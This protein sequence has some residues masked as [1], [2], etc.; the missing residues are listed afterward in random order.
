VSAALLA[1]VL[2]GQDR[3]QAW[4]TGTA[5]SEPLTAQTLAAKS[6]W[7][8]L[9]DPLKGDAVLS[10]GR[11]TA[12]VRRQGDGVDLYGGSV[13]RARLA[14]AGAAGLDRVALAEQGRTTATLEVAWK[15]AAVKLRLKRGDVALEIEPG[16]GAER[17]KVE[18]PSRFAVLPDFFADD[19][20]I[21]AAKIPVATAD[22]P[23]ENF[24]LHL[25]GSGDAAA[26]CVF[27]NRDQD[28]RVALAGE[29]EKRV[30]AGSE[31]L[32]G[33]GRKVW[34]ALI[35]G[36]GTWHSFEVRPEDAKKVRALDWTMPFPAAW[37]LD[38]TRHDGLTDSWEML[39]QQEKGHFLKPSWL[40]AESDRVKADRKRWTTVLGDFKYP[41]WI[42]QDGRGHVQPLKEESLSFRGPAV[43][44][45]INRVEGTPSERFTLVGVVQNTLGV[46]PCQY[47]LDVEGQK[48]AY[49]GRATCSVR[50]T[51]TPIYQ[52]GRQKE[53]R[54][55]I[56]KTLDEGL[57]FVRHIRGRITVYVEF[58]KKLREHLAAQASARPELRER[59][60][61][62]EKLAAEIDARFDARREAMKTPEHV[63]KMN[64]DFRKNVLDD[65]SGQAPA[66]CKAYTKALVEI[67]DNQDELSGELRWV[68][69]ALRQKAGLLMATEPKMAEIAAEI[70]KR[71]QE[72]LRNPASHEGARH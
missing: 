56:E 66:R 22:L 40:G 38:F 27:E 54:A 59:I 43:I 70:R 15:S 65:T 33:K 14:V 21:D 6:G 71:T 55:K 30:I 26:L 25:A 8:P 9:A 36:P 3:P 68:V 50:D 64:E 19:I 4:D 24:I 45:P 39:L 61:E 34:V 11:V 20:V 29:G 52:K 5:S 49:K 23:S 60:A 69:R 67:G 37:R 16:A 47:I 44:Y 7:A 18:C 51:L 1:L 10:N 53:E 72:V 62:L 41:C 31:V 63:V 12:V 57:A 13:L 35:E 46:G 42:D 32:F 28:V 48:E 58:G 17:L 2:L